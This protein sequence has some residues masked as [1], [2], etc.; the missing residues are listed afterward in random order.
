MSWFIR[1]SRH[2]GRAHKRMSLVLALRQLSSSSISLPADAVQRAA[3]NRGRDRVGE[4]PPAPLFALPLEG[5]H[6]RSRSASSLLFDRR[7]NRSPANYRQD[8]A[9]L[10]CLELIQGEVDLHLLSGFFYRTLGRMNDAH[11][12]RER[13]LAPPEIGRMR[14]ARH[15]SSRV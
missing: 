6:S 2:E 4:V 8:D 13:F 12:D 14:P 15:A 11:G 5:A 1:F 9:Q 10:K 3:S 7:R